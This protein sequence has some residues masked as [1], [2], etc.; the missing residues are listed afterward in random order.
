MVVRSF[1]V[2]GIIA[3]T[4]DTVVTS[5]LYNYTV[6]LR[7]FFFFL[8]TERGKGGGKGFDGQVIS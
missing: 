8:S 7:N 1:A 6:K 5:I 4:I 2:R 3:F